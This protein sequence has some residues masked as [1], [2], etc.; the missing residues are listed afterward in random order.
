[1]QPLRVCTVFS[2]LPFHACMFPGTLGPNFNLYLHVRSR[3]VKRRV[4][5]GDGDRLGIYA[6]TCMGLVYAVSGQKPTQSTKRH[7]SRRFLPQ[8]YSAMPYAICQA[9]ASVLL[10]GQLPPGPRSAPSA[11]LRPPRLRDP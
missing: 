8:T 7:Q 2:A 5:F 3:N 6:C 10:P 1:M 4:Y 11:W 9:S